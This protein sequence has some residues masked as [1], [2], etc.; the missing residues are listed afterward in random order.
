MNA[1]EIVEAVMTALVDGGVADNSH[2]FA[3]RIY[4]QDAS[5]GIW[6]VTATPG[7]NLYGGNNATYKIAYQLTVSGYHS[8]AEQLYGKDAAVLSSLQQLVTNNPQVIRMSMQPMADQDI[9]GAEVR[10]GSWVGTILT[11]APGWKDW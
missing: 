6:C 3:G 10:M 5:D 2:V 4:P 11:Y 8:D 9:P 7:S 1:K